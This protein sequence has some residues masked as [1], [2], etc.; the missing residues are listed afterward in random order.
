MDD[1]VGEVQDVGS[2]EAWRGAVTG[3]LLPFHVEYSAP[4]RFRGSIGRRRLGAASMIAMSSRPHR[5]ERAAEHIDDAPADYLLSLQLAGTAQFRQDGRLARVG[6]GDMVFYDSA[7]PVEIVS[8]EGYRSLCFRFP[9]D[10]LGAHRQAEALTATTLGAAHGIAPA[11]AGLLTGLHQ[12]LER[13][14]ARPDAALAAARHATELARTLF[15]DE[16]AR[17]GLLAAPDPHEELRGRIDRHIDEHL[18]DPGLSPR[19]VAAAM[20]ISP[21]HLHALLAEDGRTVAGTIRERRLGRCLA[22]LADPAEV[23][24]PVSAI[25]LRWGFTN[26]TRFGQLVKA[27][28]GRTP[29][30]YR[31][32][33]LDGTA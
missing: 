17:R 11:V 31:R 7:R 2:V 27:A 24:T 5:A 21:R 16:L 10:G 32:T 25:A 28:T 19:A 12:S 33:M 13:P 20:F 6:P 18:A 22:D 14:G 30:A 26:A 8:G 9:A 1:V 3:A 4:E 15:D 29:V 23:R